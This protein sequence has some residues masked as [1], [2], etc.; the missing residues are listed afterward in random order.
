MANHSAELVE[1]LLTL[2]P[3][4]LQGPLGANARSALPDTLG[5][6]IYGAIQPWGKIL[7]QQ[8]AHEGS[9]GKATLFGSNIAVAPSR[10][11]LANGTASHGF[12]L[13]D[14][15]QGALVHPGACV[16]PAALAVAE[17]IG[18]S[19][20]RLLHPVLTRRIFQHAPC[21]LSCPSHRAAAR[22]CWRARWRSNS[23]LRGASRCWWI[24]GPVAAR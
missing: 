14:I 9:R 15:I 8:I 10:A 4:L 13:D 1:H 5:C 23:P 7:R 2:P 12:E 24:T 16:V 11:A 3:S 18:A 21:V 6:G 19:G 22:I 17:E 20:E